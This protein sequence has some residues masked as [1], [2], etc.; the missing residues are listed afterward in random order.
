MG[1]S[2]LG[3]YPIQN[4]IHVITAVLHP[5]LSEYKNDREKDIQRIYKSSKAIISIRSIF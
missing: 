3:Y 2:S 5:I 1:N 4:L